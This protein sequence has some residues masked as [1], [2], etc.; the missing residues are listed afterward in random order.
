MHDIKEQDA[1]IAKP[2]NTGAVKRDTLS[3]TGVM[4]ILGDYSTPAEPESRVDASTLRSC[5]V[6]AR[7]VADASTVCKHCLCYVGPSP[8]YLRSLQQ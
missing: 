4:R 8:D 1:S 3:D 6:C 2:L 7:A 5:P